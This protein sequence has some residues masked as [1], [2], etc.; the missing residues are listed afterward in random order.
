MPGETLPWTTAA[1][2]PVGPRKSPFLRTYPPQAWARARR[3]NAAKKG[4]FGFR[5]TARTKVLW[6]R[7]RGKETPVTPASEAVW[8]R[9]R[10]RDWGVPTIPP[11]D[12]V[13]KRVRKN[14]V[15]IH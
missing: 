4:L 12:P 15:E 14:S 5:L 2:T 9:G 10:L 13:R 3:A 1:L 11:G 8:I 6:T 7:T